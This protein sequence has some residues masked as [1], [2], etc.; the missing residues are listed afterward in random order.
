MIYIPNFIGVFVNFDKCYKSF[1][2]L[3]INPNSF[4]SILY[5]PCFYKNTTISK[6]ITS[7]SQ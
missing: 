1:I 7:I 2:K 5:F 6:D 4:S 3:F